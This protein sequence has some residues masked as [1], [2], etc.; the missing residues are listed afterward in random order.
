M[1]SVADR[2]YFRRRLVNAVSLVLS[3]A[4]VLSESE[5]LSL[6]ESASEV[7]SASASALLL[8]SLPWWWWSGRHW[9]CPTLRLLASTPPTCPIG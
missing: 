3:D 7:A 1:A 4:L 5:V 6:S 9:S 8:P 2:L